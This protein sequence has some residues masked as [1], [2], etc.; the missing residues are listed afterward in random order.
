[1]AKKLEKEHR[2]TVADADAFVNH[3][4]FPGLTGTQSSVPEG[5]F[6]RAACGCRVWVVLT[7]APLAV[8]ELFSSWFG[9]CDAMAPTVQSLMIDIEDA[10]SKLQWLTVPVRA[11]QYVVSSHRPTTRPG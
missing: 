6:A 10:E 11:S 7:S 5:D 9:S 8:V 4:K 2:V 3:L 1:M